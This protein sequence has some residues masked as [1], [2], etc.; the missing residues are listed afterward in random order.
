MAQKSLLEEYEA[1]YELFKETEK[2]VQVL[3]KAIQV[4]IKSRQEDAS[5]ITNERSADLM[6]L[7]LNELRT[8]WQ[9][10]GTWHFVC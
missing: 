10:E 7:H 4:F 3:R 6:K 8:A 5:N 2:E 9:H 1:S